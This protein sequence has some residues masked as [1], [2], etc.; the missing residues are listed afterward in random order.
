MSDRKITIQGVTKKYPEN[1]TYLQIA[2]E[3]QSKYENPIVLVN[4]DGRLRELTKQESKDCTLEFVTT[5]ESDGYLTYVRGLVLVL[6]RA[7]G[8][9]M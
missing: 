3:Y 1:I 2:K 5:A 6:M 9:K 7:A 8:A 4:V